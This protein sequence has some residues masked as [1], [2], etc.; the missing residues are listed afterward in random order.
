M[1]NSIHSKFIFLST[2]LTTFVASMDI[3]VFAQSNIVKDLR[4]SNIDCLFYTKGITGCDSKNNFANQILDLMVNLAPVV[5]TLVIVAAGYEYFNDEA[6]KKTSSQS[7]LTSAVI[8]LVVVYLARPITAVL[9]NTF[10][11]KNDNKD[12]F[13]DPA[14]LV[15]FINVFIN[16]LLGM[17]GIA[18]VGCIVL[19]GY[20]YIM[21]FVLNAGKSQ[22]QVAPF[23][24]IR[25]GVVGLLVVIFARPLV[26]IIQKV[27]ETT[28]NTSNVEY[29]N[30]K[31]LITGKIAPEISPILELVRIV[32]SQFL[33]PLAS[34]ATV[35]SFIAA[36]YMFFFVGDN[37]DRPKKARDMLG[38]AATGLVVVLI[39]ATMVQLI[40]YFVRP[41]DFVKGEVSSPTKQVPIIKQQ[42]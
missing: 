2:L 21:K 28:V 42:K 23:D 40:L 12:F 35:L 17:A 7:T 10:V 27:F 29:V 3:P 41:G 34:V 13:I 5:A 25:N 11:T 20:E 19:G 39:S 26:T 31:P 38:N 33:I 16:L 14:P 32:L 4:I 8:G 22:G 37:A 1:L 6:L 30:G 18:A 15:E 36:A 9:Q 24:L